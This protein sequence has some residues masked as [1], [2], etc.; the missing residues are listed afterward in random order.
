MSYFCTMS[1]YIVYFEYYSEGESG[2]D[3]YR[4]ASE[5]EAFG[6]MEELKQAI[7]SNFCDTPG[8]ETIDEHDF[9]G[10]MDNQTKDYAKV[11]IQVL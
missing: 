7:I 4:F 9:F 10:I 11:I 5:A 2:N 1:K 8:C 6:K 3:K